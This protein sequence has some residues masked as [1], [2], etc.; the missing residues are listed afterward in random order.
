MRHASDRDMRDDLVAGRVDHRDIG[1]VPIGHEDVVGQIVERDG[2]RMDLYRATRGD[3]VGEVSYF[4]SASPANIV[5]VSPARLLRFEDSDLEY[6]VERHPRIAAHI[7]R[8]LNLSQ[9]RR[10][11][12]SLR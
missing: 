6:L 7:Y 3:V 11:V 9:A 1:R 4:S 12:D 8:N 5:A 10:L 2:R